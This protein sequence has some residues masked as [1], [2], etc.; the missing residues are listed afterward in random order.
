M[1]RSIRPTRARRPSDASVVQTDARKDSVHVHAVEGSEMS[2][3]TQF[4]YT[5]AR[6]IRLHRITLAELVRARRSAAT[7]LGSPGLAMPLA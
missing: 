3:W 1:L 7:R 2:I 6:A 4:A 5:F